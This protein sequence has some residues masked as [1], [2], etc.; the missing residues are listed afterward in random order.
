MDTISVVL[1]Y[2]S[3]NKISSGL[4]YLHGLTLISTW[5]IYYIHYK[6]W[7]QITYAFLNFNGAT[8]EV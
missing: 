6:V 3:N 7:N 2:C 1:F 5:M 4:F 8:F